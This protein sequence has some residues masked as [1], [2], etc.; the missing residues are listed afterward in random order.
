MEGKKQ[1][2]NYIESINK[3]YFGSMNKKH[4]ENKLEFLLSEDFLEIVVID[5]ESWIKNEMIFNGNIFEYNFV[6]KFIEEFKNK[7]VFVDYKNYTI[8]IEDETIQFPRF[9]IYTQMKEVLENYLITILYFKTTILW[10]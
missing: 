6:I 2:I 8:T 4:D 5:F 7:F 9:E 3:H 10:E 1:K